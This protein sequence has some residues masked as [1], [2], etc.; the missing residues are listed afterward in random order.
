MTLAPAKLGKGGVKFGKGG[1]RQ[2]KFPAGLITLALSAKGMNY[3]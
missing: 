3:E 1:K 2:V